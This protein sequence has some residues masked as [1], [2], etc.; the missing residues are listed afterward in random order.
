MQAHR[1][2]F[3]VLAA[4][5]ASAMRLLQCSPARSVRGR[6]CPVRCSDDSPD[7]EEPLSLEQAFSERLKKE[8]GATQFK[9]RTDATRAADTVKDGLQSVANKVGDASKPLREIGTTRPGSDGLLSQGQWNLTVGFFALLIVLSVGNAVINAPPGGASSGGSSID[10][11]TS[12]GYA[13]QFGR[14]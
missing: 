1:L 12:D 10:S 13:L 7:V 6:A 8:G 4:H 5:C 14:Q 9:L 3:L 2:A 11:F